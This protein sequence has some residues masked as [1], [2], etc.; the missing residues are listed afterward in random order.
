MSTATEIFEQA[1]A[2]IKVGD[3]LDLISRCTE[4][5]I[6]EFPFAPAGRPRRVEG[7]D[8]VS[9]SGANFRS[10]AGA[11]RQQPRDTPDY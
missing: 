11:A 6:F 7:R 1:L 8:A 2:G 3:A 5:V 10:R 4:D 9:L